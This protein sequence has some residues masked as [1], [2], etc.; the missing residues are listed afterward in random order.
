M[1][2]LVLTLG[3]GLGISLAYGHIVD[4]IVVAVVMLPGIGLLLLWAYLRTKPNAQQ[5]GDAQREG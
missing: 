1:A 5:R 4:A 2:L 3:A